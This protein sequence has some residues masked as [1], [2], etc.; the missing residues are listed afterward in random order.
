MPSTPATFRQPRGAPTAA[1]YMAVPEGGKWAWQEEP[2]VYKIRRLNSEERSDLASI[3]GIR[4]GLRLSRT[5]RNRRLFRLLGMASHGKIPD[6]AGSGRSCT[7]GLRLFAHSCSERSCR[8]SL[9]CLWRDLHR[10]FSAVAMARGGASARPVR[11]GRRGFGVDSG[12]HHPV[13]ASVSPRVARNAIRACPC[14]A[15]RT[16]SY[17]LPLTSKCDLWHIMSHN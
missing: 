8:T 11:H 15:A 3:L 12:H 9:R 5:F 4:H 2:R 10:G 14:G 16:A 13:R 17:W 1:P 6:M 7:G